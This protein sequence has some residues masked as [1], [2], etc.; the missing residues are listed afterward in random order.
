ML[1][2]GQE[3][4]ILTSGIFRPQALDA[5]NRIE[6]L[7]RAMTVTTALTRRTVAMLAVVLAGAIAWSAFVRVPVQIAGRG[8]L[9]DRSGSL[10][11]PV[12]APS[13]G[14]VAKFLVG[15]G[16]KVAPGDPLAHLTFPDRELQLRKA[17]AELEDAR[18][19][20][21]RKRVLRA[22]DARTEDE[23]YKLKASALDSRIEGL[24]RRRGWLDRRVADLVGLEA[25][26]FVTNLTVINARVSLE[27]ATDELGQA[28]AERV[29]LDSQREQNSAQRERDALA[30]RLELE[31]LDQDQATLAATLAADGVLR[32]DVA[33]R[34]AAVN[35]RPGALVAAGDGVV[36]LLVEGAS[37]SGLE[38]IV[39]VP[40]EAGKR[41]RPGDRTLVAPASLPE[42]SRE[43]LV[44]KVISVSDVPVSL[45]T[46]RNLLGN[47]QLASEAARSGPPFALRVRLDPSPDG[48]G[49]A[50][51]T[52]KAPGFLLTP[53][54]PLRASVTVEHVPLLALAVP[55]LKRFLG[56]D[57]T[58]EARAS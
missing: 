28:R 48:S 52:A 11:A 20:V 21:E 35:T 46:L 45:V 23:A 29:T 4:R 17:R 55:A 7:P 47:D 50:W 14:Y 54:T 34:V 16:D 9:V 1:A 6:A 12:A 13:Q 15:V 27:G 25:K 57:D 41:V 39:L 44:A 51:T 3:G 56:L 10:V 32:A 24:E 19:N 33:G 22:A 37:G 38:A 2:A 36:D 5:A 40:T 43:R 58:G 30:D 42:G 18:R 26:G 31:R 49:Y 8:M 53:G